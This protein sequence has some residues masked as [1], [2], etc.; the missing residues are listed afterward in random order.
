[1]SENA[2]QGVLS[3]YSTVKWFNASKGFGLITPMMAARICSSTT[4][5]SDRRLRYADE[6]QKVNFEVVRAKKA[7]VQQR[8]AAVISAATVR[9]QGSAIRR[10]FFYSP[11]NTRLYGAATCALDGVLFQE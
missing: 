6:N 1:M 8:Q 3:E 7:L 2:D 11:I 10:A 5:K 9:P 4:Q